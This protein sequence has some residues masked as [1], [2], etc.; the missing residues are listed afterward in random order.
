MEEGS[1]IGLLL[2]I[3]IGLVILTAC[4]LVAFALLFVT[5]AAI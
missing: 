2:G 3:V 5:W 1:Q 4:G